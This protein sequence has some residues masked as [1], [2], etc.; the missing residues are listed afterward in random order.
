MMLILVDDD[1][2]VSCKSYANEKEKGVIL[3]I[4]KEIKGLSPLRNMKVLLL[5]EGGLS[6]D[7]VS[8]IFDVAFKYTLCGFIKGLA[9]CYNFDENKFLPVVTEYLDSWRSKI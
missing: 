9:E 3:D 6:D 1:T 2:L 7:Q 8:F 4:V 5:E